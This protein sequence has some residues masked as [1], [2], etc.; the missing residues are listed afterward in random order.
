MNDTA[1][2]GRSTRVLAWF[3][4]V[5]YG[6]GAPLM[7]ILEHGSQLFSQRFDLPPELI[8]SHLRGPVPPAR[9][10]CSCAPWR[11]GRPPAS[12]SR[13]WARSLRT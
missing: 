13:P 3:L 4:A 9:S 10:A 7:A 6:V 8:V 1:T 11:R 5:S 12:R 2:Y